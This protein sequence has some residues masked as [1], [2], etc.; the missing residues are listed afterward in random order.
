[1][2]ENEVTCIACET[3]PVEW[4][5]ETKKSLDGMV[6]ACLILFPGSK[7]V[8]REIVESAKRLAESADRAG[9]PQPDVAPTYDGGVEFSWV[10]Q[11]GRY[12]V[13]FISPTSAKY[14]LVLE[15]SG[16]VTPDLYMAFPPAE[17]NLC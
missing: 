17:A 16:E 5:D 6:G 12:E 14:H 3:E 13:E 4:L 8:A 1:M 15:R 9:M 2:F 10:G 7:Q 11:N